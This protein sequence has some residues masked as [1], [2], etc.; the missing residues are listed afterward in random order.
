M[1]PVLSI[2]SP[3]NHTHKAIDQSLHRCH[4]RKDTQMALSPPSMDRSNL[5]SRDKAVD[6]RQLEWEVQ[7]QVQAAQD[8]HLNEAKVR[9]LHLL[10]RR[11][12]HGSL[13]LNRDEDRALS[14]LLTGYGTTLRLLD[15]L[16]T[17]RWRINS[18]RR[19]RG[20][21]ATPYIGY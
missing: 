20:N 3:V 17:F 14:H 1:F 7:V 9:L 6:P 18:R 21:E 13:L 5:H 11:M 12:A 10:D 16:M 19:T 15:R 8:D 2:W 4:Y